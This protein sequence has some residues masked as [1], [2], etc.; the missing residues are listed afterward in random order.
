[1]K[2]SV[3]HMILMVATGVPRVPQPARRRLMRRC[4][5][6]VGERTGVRHGCTFTPGKVSIGTDSFVNF[7]CV[8]DASAPITIGDG[9]DIGFHTE[10][11]TSGHA[12]AD[13]RRRAGPVFHEPISIE[14]GCWLGA[15]VKVLPGVTIRRGCIIAAGAVVT[16]D[17]QPHGL[18]AG[19][20]A[21]RIRELEAGE[22]GA[23]AHSPSDHVAPRRR[24]ETERYPAISPSR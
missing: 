24:P 14:S 6:H 13:D 8:F 4:E 12:I 15:G 22:R 2:D 23:E 19:V 5:V 11:I 7:G 3:R 10:L 1:M 18:Y 20:P 17:C 9:V 16:R 21:R